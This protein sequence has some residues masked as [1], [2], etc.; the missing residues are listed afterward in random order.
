MGKYSGADTVV[1]ICAPL[2]VLYGPYT[3]S[4]G[5]LVKRFSARGNSEPDLR[6]RTT[7]AGRS[8]VASL[9]IRLLYL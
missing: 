4:I 7:G 6:T 1:I 3:N 8:G 5:Y 9:I 2:Q